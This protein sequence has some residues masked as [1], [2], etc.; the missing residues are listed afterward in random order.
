[1]PFY[2]LNEENQIFYEYRKPQKGGVTCIFVNALTGNL[3]TWTEI[4]GK[5]LI[6]DGNGYIAYNLR[7]QEKSKHDK[8]LI[9]SDE[10][11][12]LDLINLIDFLN[13]KNII[14]VGLSIGGLFAAMSLKKGII[15]KG[16]VLI[17]TLRKPSERLNW[18]NNSMVNA[19]KLGGTNL[20]LDM[21]MPVITSP[22]F[23]DK[24]KNSALKYENYIGLDDYNGISKLI[25]AG[26]TT[27]WNFNWSMIDIPTLVMT[28]HYDKVFRVPKDIDEII[29]EIKIA[30]RIEIP[31]CGHLIPVENPELFHYHLNG[32]INSIKK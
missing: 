31:E 18:I 4:I 30:I 3:S 17:N 1:M 27:N 22:T 12:V 8:N 29:R 16:L 14:L 25:Y 10:L 2:K 23:L 11:I 13:P 24:I 6:N 32:F 20:I 15:A 5:K 28:G 21:I 26:F 19:V 9:L 7:G